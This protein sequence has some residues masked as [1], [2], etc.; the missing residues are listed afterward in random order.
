MSLNPIRGPSNDC[1]CD[2]VTSEEDRHYHSRHQH[3]LHHEGLF[4]DVFQV[5]TNE[6]GVYYRQKSLRGSRFHGSEEGHDVPPKTHEVHCCWL[7]LAHPQNDGSLDLCLISLVCSGQTPFLTSGS[8][9]S[10]EAHPQLT[11]DHRSISVHP[12]LCH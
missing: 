6:Q 12:L 3:Q 4:H 11:G 10:E 2:V 7:D 1:D 5:K 9:T 8:L